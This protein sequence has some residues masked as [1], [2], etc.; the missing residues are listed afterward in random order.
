MLRKGYRHTYRTP[1][2][3]QGHLGGLKAESDKLRKIRHENQENDSGAPWRMK[4]KLNYPINAVT[5]YTFESSIVIYK[6]ANYGVRH[7]HLRNI[8]WCKNHHTNT[9][10]TVYT[11]KF[12]IVH[13]KMVTEIPGTHV[14]QEIDMSTTTAQNGSR[15]AG[16]RDGTKTYLYIY[17]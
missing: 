11:L 8:N 15:A 6:R 2:T 17:I 7:V 3:K 12:H 9:E 10:P 4:N 5:E 16:S 13:E 1:R 14:E